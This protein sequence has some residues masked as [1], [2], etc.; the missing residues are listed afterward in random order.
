MAP[1]DGVFCWV[2]FIVICWVGF[3]F[4]GDVRHSIT[5]L[6]VSWVQISMVNLSVTL[7]DRKI[8]SSYVFSHPHP[9]PI[10]IP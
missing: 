1:L 9:I 3:N 10:N 2:A 5:L 8:V 7:L 4:S 6:L